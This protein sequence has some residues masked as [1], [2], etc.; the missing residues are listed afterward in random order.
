MHLNFPPYLIF[1][2][3]WGEGEVVVEELSEHGGHERGAAAGHVEVRV[4]RR[5]HQPRVRQQV[6]GVRCRKKGGISIR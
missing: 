4:H 1:F 5:A 2:Y 3:L 6:G